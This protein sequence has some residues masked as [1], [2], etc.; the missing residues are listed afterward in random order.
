MK[1]KTDGDEDEEAT[2]DDIRR[3]KQTVLTKVKDALAAKVMLQLAKPK[4][5]RGGG[6]QTRA[7]SG[8]D[9]EAAAEVERQAQDR[10]VTRS[11]RQREEDLAKATTHTPPPKKARSSVL[12]SPR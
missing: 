7:S 5:D 10:A 9:T 4:A 2:Q 3:G 1:G 11:K 12:K 6:T 8:T